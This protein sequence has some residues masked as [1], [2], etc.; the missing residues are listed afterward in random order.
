MNT[1][2]L[3]AFQVI[4]ACG[5]FSKAAA[6]LYISQPA[7]SKQIGKLEQDLDAVLFLRKPRGVELTTKGEAVL[8][9]A[10]I[11]LAQVESLKE[12]RSGSDRIAGNIVFGCPSVGIH[13]LLPSFLPEFTQKNPGIYFQ[14]KEADSPQII[15]GILDDVINCGLVV[16]PVKNPDL[17]YDRLVRCP[18]TCISLKG[19]FLPHNAPITPAHISKHPFIAYDEIIKH[20]S[21][22]NAALTKKNIFPRTVIRARSTDTILEI[23]K[24]GMGLAF[25]PEYCLNKS[26][27]RKLFSTHI[28]KGL[29]LHTEF[30]LVIKRSHLKNALFSRFYRFVSELF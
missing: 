5:S 23:A 18:L 19:R 21:I 28:I 6:K 13:Y 22:I 29:S 27:Y 2:A 4:A 3:L 30:G 7:L 17:E 24:M 11:I 8:K 9:A 10:N 1:D 20:Q 14:I 25:V 12:K 16:G 15:S 26:A